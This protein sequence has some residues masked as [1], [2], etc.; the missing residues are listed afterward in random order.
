MENRSTPKKGLHMTRMLI[1]VS[2]LFTASAHAD[3]ASYAIESAATAEW[4]VPHP[5][6]KIYGSTYYVG[7]TGLSSIL[8]DSGSGLILLDG[9]L[10]QS[11]PLIEKNIASLGFHVKDIKY[12]ANSHSHFDHAG[13]IAELQR[14]TGATV[15]ASS[16]GAKALRV[17]HAI[18]GDPQFGYADHAGFPPVN[19]V[20]AVR[21]G[22]TI[23]LGDVTL[24]A[25]YTPGHTPGSTT[26]TWQSCEEN[27]CLDVVYADSLN[28]VSAPGFHYTAT[29]KHPDTSE[30][31]RHSIHAVAAL[32]CDILLTVHPD[33]SNTMDKLD[34]I[35]HQSPSNPFID[36]QACVKYA[37]DA[38]KQLDQR[39]ADEKSGRL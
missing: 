11:V 19:D 15:L 7:V 36:K 32:P 16:W 24:V 8:I 6:Q 39:I 9:D 38:E 5:A 28:S 31:F 2:L 25:H 23:A 10:V 33:L 27:K 20:R 3:A 21:D 18:E 13:G 26:W 12:I 37:A 30:R 29:K 4:N 1:A 22:E 35:K 34:A 17:G 14:V